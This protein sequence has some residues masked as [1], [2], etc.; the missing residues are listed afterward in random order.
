MT[1][2]ELK[3]AAVE[4][5]TEWHE[6]PDGSA[7]KPLFEESAIKDFIAGAKWMEAHTPLPEDTVLFNKGVEEGKRLMME[8]AI[9]AEISVKFPVVG[10]SLISVIDMLK[11]FKYGDKVRIIVIP[12]ED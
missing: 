9:D 1:D 7:W 2:E 8:E 6:N 4:Y 5:A 12:K 3:K 11:D 10:R